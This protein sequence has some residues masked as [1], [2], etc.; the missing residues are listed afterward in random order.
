VDRLWNAGVRSASKLDVAYG[1][2][3]SGSRRYSPR[4]TGYTPNWGRDGLITLAF[5][6][7]FGNIHQTK[8]LMRAQLL[9]NLIAILA[10]L[11]KGGLPI[12]P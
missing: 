7:V 3:A 1:R 9:K 6:N 11:P 8:L 4:S 5:L 10:F 2:R 12:V